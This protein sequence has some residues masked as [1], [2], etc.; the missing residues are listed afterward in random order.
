M[1]LIAFQD[2][3]I[4]IASRRIQ[5][6]IVSIFKR[7]P[8]TSLKMLETL[9]RY[10]RRMLTHLVNGRLSMS[11]VRIS[12]TSKLQK[13][14]SS[15]KTRSEACTLVAWRSILAGLRVTTRLDN[16]RTCSE[17]SHDLVD[18]IEERKAFFYDRIGVTH[19]LYDSEAIEFQELA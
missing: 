15:A 16:S 1:R 2:S 18:S 3:A 6:L 11:W 9:L 4:A 12:A 8:N 5:F 17:V 7:A 10:S 19:V 13:I 14:A